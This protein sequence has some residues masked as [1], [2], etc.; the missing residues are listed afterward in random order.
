VNHK[1]QGFALKTGGFLQLIFAA[2]FVL[3]RYI[4]ALRVVNGRLMKQA[5]DMPTPFNDPTQ[6]EAAQFIHQQSFLM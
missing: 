2:A 4:I 3:D 6:I 5:L 1:L